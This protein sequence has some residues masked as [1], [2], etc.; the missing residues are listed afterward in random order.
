[1]QKKKTIYKEC[2]RREP[3][4]ITNFSVQPRSKLND[5]Q[6]ADNT[7]V[8]PHCITAVSHINPFTPELNIWGQQKGKRI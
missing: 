4:I 1:M 2:L 3:P 8:L 5:V 6:V 7:L